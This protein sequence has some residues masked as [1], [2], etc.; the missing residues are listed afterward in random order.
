MNTMSRKMGFIQQYRYRISVVLGITV[1]V[2]VA[3]ILL[4]NYFTDN[5][6]TAKAEPPLDY[7]VEEPEVALT[8][9]VSVVPAFTSQLD[10]T[11]SSA[12]RPEEHMPSVSDNSES[13]FISSNVDKVRISPEGNLLLVLEKNT[14][15]Q[16][17]TG[18]EQL[19]KLYLTDV[20]G[21][22]IAVIE[23]T[24]VLDAKFVDAKTVMYQKMY[25]DAG[26][27]LY[28]IESR[29]SDKIISTEDYS[30]F[31]NVDIGIDNRYYFI[32]QRTGKVGYLQGV[33]GKSTIIEQKMLDI[34][35]NYVQAG[36]FHTMSVSPDEKWIAYLESVSQDEYNTLIKI[37][38]A[39]A[40]SV[41]QL[42]YKA[43]TN[44]FPGGFH[45]SAL[46]QWSEDSNFIKA[47][48]SCMVIDISKKQSKRLCDSGEE[49]RL[50]P[51]DKF[52]HVAAVSINDD[53]RSVLHVH[54][55]EA[56]SIELP[57]N[58]RDLSWIAK[59]KLLLIIG[60]KLYV[61][62][63]KTQALEL[64]REEREDYKILATNE[65]EGRAWVK[66]GD[67][68]HLLQIIR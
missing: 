34:E 6:K 16:K 2:V 36:A 47:G 26:V 5:E 45:S 52:Q 61:F 19:S 15:E 50:V 44:I 63:T 41:D 35:S 13:L 55:E 64:V 66:G 27:Y 31:D 57:R 22:S 24:F 54:G 23:E 67:A 65:T 62:D 10:V 29:E 28:R 49:V 60:K 58:I 20:D 9:A 48:E 38:P 11:E 37:Y 43:T 3:A 51:A 4:I 12:K 53:V 68:I 25:R 39:D 33:Q 17:E 59:E 14:E 40:K 42:Y 32:Q 21:A 46:I 18:I 7:G 30:S 56:E 1:A 8:Q